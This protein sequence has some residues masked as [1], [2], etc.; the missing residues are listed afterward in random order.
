M[1]IYHLS[2]KPVSRSSGRTAT[3]SIAYRAG[4]AIKDERTGKEHDYTKRSGVVFTQLHTPNNLQI[5]RA[6][7]W[8]LAETT[9]TRKNSRTAREIVVNLPYELDESCRSELVNDFAKDLANKYGVAVDVAVHLPDA[10]GDNRNHHAHIMLTTR[11]LERLES[12]RIALT[13]K[14]QLEMSN[15]QLKE[16]N[17]PT[18]R[19]ELK[20]IRKQWA[21]LT[22]DYMKERN[23]PVTIDHRSHAERGLDQLP[24]QKLGWEASAMERKGIATDKGNYNRMVKEYNRTMNQVAVLDKSIQDLKE[25]R[26]QSND[27]ARDRIER[28][29]KLTESAAYNTAWAA[30]RAGQVNERVNDSQQGIEGAERAINASTGAINQADRRIAEHQRQLE[31]KQGIKELYTQAVKGEQ[32]VNAY[33]KRLADIERQFENVNLKP[34]RTE[35]AQHQKAYD[36]AKKPMMTSQSKWEKLKLEKRTILRNLEHQISVK[37][38]QDKGKREQQAK[39]WIAKNEPQIVQ[40]AKQ[41]QQDIKEYRKQT[42]PQK[43]PQQQQ[44]RIV[45]DNDKGMEL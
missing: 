7:L 15:T 2:T 42:E 11:K 5:D 37:E 41:G 17:L 4:I 32:A 21:D 26:E 28:T 20:L 31:A 39:D 27:R 29:I 33:D 30:K 36:D 9:E 16:R 24:T 35:L 19:D 10:E 22:N 45:R 34:L 38:F 13:S 6:E 18:A 1:A 14:S 23:I 44:V 3:A 43:T 8:N 40:E 12:G 25:Q